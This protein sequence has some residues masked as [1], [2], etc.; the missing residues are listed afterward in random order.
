MAAGRIVLPPYF[1]ARDRNGRLVSGALLYV[2]TNGTTTKASIYSN[3]ALTTP[4]ANPV[5]A[6]SSGQFP[7]I[8]AD[9]G[10]TGTPVLY[11]LAVTAADGEN[12]GN[13]SVLDDWQPSVDGETAAAALAEAAATAAEEFLADALA[14]Q[15]TGDDAAA[16]ATRAAKSANLSDLAD[17][18][19][20]RTNIGAANATYFNSSG[21][22]TII[23]TTADGV[24]I[25]TVPAAPFQ[26]GPNTGI[27]D[28]NIV[29]GRT[30]SGAQSAYGHSFSDFPLINATLS[31]GDFEYAYNSY[32]ARPNVSGSNTYN[33]IAPY[34][35]DPQISGSVV[36]RDG[37]GYLS[38]GNVSGTASV[39]QYTHFLAADFAKADTGAIGTQ[40]GFRCATI[41][42]SA[43][44]WAFYVDSEDNDSKTGKLGVCLNQ[45]SYSVHPSQ[46]I[47]INAP[48][49]LPCAISFRVGMASKGFFGVSRSAGDF[50]FATAADDLCVRVNSGDFMVSTDGGVSANF[51]IAE[52]SGNLTCTGSGAFSGALSGTTGAFSGSVSLTE[53]SAPLILNA[54]TTQTVRFQT[55]ATTKS[56]EGVCATNG[57]LITGSLAGDHMFRVQ[58]GN[59]IVSTN[60]GGGAGFSV[61]ASNAGVQLN[62]GPTWTS[63]TGSPEGVVTAPVGSFYSRTDGGAATSWYVKE[64]G[65]GSTGW[66]AK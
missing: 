59:F 17:A 61:L 25:N 18:A 1:P 33:H 21:S 47:D 7:A 4:L 28:P 31:T 16:I 8:Y 52:T 29:S 6:N 42:G 57:D 38:N 55:S 5:A 2:Y 51:K 14:I 10:T 44:Q 23:R 27:S 60:S 62:A 49:G 54:A 39:T 43:D 65:S 3:L 35:A 22:A 66:T 50:G 37:W 34:Q 30:I 12:I 24:G 19:T 26:V 46:A 63:G 58:G 36:I 13:P 45:G 20:A 40:F 11:T 48:T 53:G 41:A 64:S 9:A 15:A 56:F 32:D